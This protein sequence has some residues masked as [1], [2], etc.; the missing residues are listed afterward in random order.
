MNYQNIEQQSVLRSYLEGSRQLGNIFWA[1]AVSAGGIGFFLS[2]LSS[3]FKVN[4][5]FFSD[6]TQ[7]SFIPQGIVLVLRCH[8]IE[9]HI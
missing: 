9:T 7:L 1:F 5:L 4:L 8:H 3:F 2:G 6:A